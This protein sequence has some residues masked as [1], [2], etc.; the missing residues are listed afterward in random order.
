MLRQHHTVSTNADTG[1]LGQ[2]QYKKVL[3]LMLDLE[4]KVD[5]RVDE[6]QTDL[7]KDILKLL[8]DRELKSEISHIIEDKIDNLEFSFNSRILSRLDLL[9]KAYD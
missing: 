2:S 3:E 9:E 6:V 8:D 7:R 4:K 1:G 5:M